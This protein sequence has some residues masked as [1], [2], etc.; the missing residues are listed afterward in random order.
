MLAI[1]ET[2]AREEHNP[3][4]EPYSLERRLNVGSAWQVTLTT[5]IKRDAGETRGSGA[6]LPFFCV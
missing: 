5:K 6:P 2:A 4:I 3:P 1:S